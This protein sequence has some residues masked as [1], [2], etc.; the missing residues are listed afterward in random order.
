MDA[1]GFLGLGAMGKRMAGH[2]LAAGHAL[3]V[4]NRTAS[5]AEELV[6]AGAMLCASPREAA[7]GA[8][9]VIAMV[10]DDAASERVWFG[11]DGAAAGLGPDAIAIESSTITPAWARRLAAQLPVPLVEAPV[12]GSRPQADSATLIHFAA[13]EA[14]SVERARPV[15]SRM[16]QAIYPVGPVGHAALIKL[17]VNALFATQVESL[18]EVL[19]VLREAGIPASEAM[20]VLGELPT[21]SPAAKGA[22]ALTAAEAYDPLFPIDLVA[23]DMGYAVDTASALG[24]NAPVLS[25][26]R[27]SYEQA[28]QAGHGGLNINAVAKLFMRDER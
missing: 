5:A 23:K 13:G 18:A 14:E 2:V 12:V 7:T 6:S 4:W 21:M 19:G 16:G 20:A 24:A 3:K 17:A 22:G 25:A 15:L 1:I 8:A 28:R 26:V 11:K 27:D 9:F 10:T